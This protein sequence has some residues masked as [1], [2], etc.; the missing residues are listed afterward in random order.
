MAFIFKNYLRAQRLANIRLTC[1]SVP[2]GLG[3]VRASG[4]RS[5]IVA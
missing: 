2:E 1:K 5:H 3:M 4:E